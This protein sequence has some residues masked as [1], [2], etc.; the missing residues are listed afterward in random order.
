VNDVSFSV[1]ED[2]FQG[3]IGPNGAGKS[4]LFDMISGFHKPTSGRVWLRESDVTALAPHARCQRGLSRSFQIVDT[5]DSLTVRENVQLA[6]QAMDDN[7]HHPLKD[8]ASLSAVNERT[9]E[10]LESVKLAEVAE[11]PVHELSYGDHRKLELAL[12]LASDPA[13]LLLDEPT[14]GLGVNESR[15]MEEL[16]GEIAVDKTVLLTEHDVEMIMNVCDEILVLHEG[17]LIA[18]G[19]PEEIMENRRVQNAYLGGQQA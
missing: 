12:A 7:R 1:P 4:T 6:A 14:A 3:I 10:V 2:R 13:V 18:E 16:I 11:L 5:F 17:A 19:T 8:S 15:T 9:G